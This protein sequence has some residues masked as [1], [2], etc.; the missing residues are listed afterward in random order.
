MYMIH[1]WEHTPSVV[2]LAIR[3]ILCLYSYIIYTNIGRRNTSAITS[4]SSSSPEKILDLALVFFQNIKLIG[5]FLYLDTY[6]VLGTTNN[7]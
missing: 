7:N 4:I 6:Y 2:A 5:I 1:D 3:S